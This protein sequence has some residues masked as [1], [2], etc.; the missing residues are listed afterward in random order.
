VISWTGLKLLEYTCSTRF[1]KAADRQ[2]LQEI[3]AEKKNRMRVS[4]T[5]L[6][7]VLL[8]VS[9][10][11]VGEPFEY[12]PDDGLK[13]GP[14]LF[15]GEDGEITILNTSVQSKRQSEQEQDEGQSSGQ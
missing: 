1:F 11:C 3:N 8:L 9:S 12:I 7:G 14:G 15:S 5:V 10:G 6:G 13:P 2:G 4:K